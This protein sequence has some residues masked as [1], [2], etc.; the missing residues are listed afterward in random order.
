[1]RSDSG[2]TLV[3]ALMVIVLLGTMGTGLLY[4]FAGLGSY[5]QARVVQASALAQEKIEMIIAGKKAN[6][7]NTV[8]SEPSAALAAP[9]E[10]FTREVEA[11]CVNEADL[12]LAAGTMPDCIDTD[13]KA[14]RVKVTVS[15]NGGSADFT[16]IITDH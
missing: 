1:M 2:F 11:Y 12:E 9:Y 4:Y 7:F 13:I 8:V 15:W 10:A 14:K 16:T 3:E 6:G 5:G